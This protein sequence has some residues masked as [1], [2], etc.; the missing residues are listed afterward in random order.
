MK[1]L[2]RHWYD[3]G[4]V[5]VVPVLLWAFLGATSTV[6]LISIL[7]LAAVLIH[8]FEE[9]RLPGGEPWVL[10]EV[11]MKSSGHPDRL[12]TNELSSI[13]IN[14]MAWVVY[15]LAAIFPDQVWLGLAPILMGFPAQFVIHGILTNRRLKTW[16]NPGLGAVVLGHLPLAIWYVI[17]VYQAGIINWWDWIF[18][19]LLLGFFMGFVMQIV[20]FRVLA[21]RGANRWN[22]PLEEYGKWDRE[23][24]LRRAGIEPGPVP[25]PP[26][27]EP[28][29]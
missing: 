4:G 25:S 10:N 3:I 2:L 16:Y 19:I 27:P 8:Q 29:R 7:N 9:Y 5:L 18:G 1:F 13:W 14:G 12:P 28:G 6:Q 23:R 21:P 22:Y 26:V 24:R 20:G 17:A 11:F 15:L